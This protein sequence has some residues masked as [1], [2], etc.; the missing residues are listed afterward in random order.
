M[1]LSFSSPVPCVLAV[2]A[3]LA[4]AYSNHFHNGFHFD[5]S[6]SIEDNIYVRDLKHIPRYF[7][8]ATTFSVLPLNQS[9]RPVLQTTFAIDYWLGGGY[10]PLAF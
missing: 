10:T 5:D 3:L 9:Y 4:V 2:A 7:T 6:H 8:D 1:K